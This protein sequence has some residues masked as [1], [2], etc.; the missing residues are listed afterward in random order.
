MSRRTLGANPCGRRVYGA[1]DWAAI[2]GAGPDGSAAL[3]PVQVLLLSEVFQSE[4][5]RPVR[6]PLLEGSNKLQGT[7]MQFEAHANHRH[8]D[9]SSATG[10]AFF[11]MA[12]VIRITALSRATLYRRIAEG[13]FPSSCA[14]GRTRLWLAAWGTSALDR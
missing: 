12:D 2:A 1:L 13:K 6:K 4:I 14:F 9:L 11:R 10:P 8:V 7:L 3:V 5:Q